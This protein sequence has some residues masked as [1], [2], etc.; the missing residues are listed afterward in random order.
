M[1]A[2]FMKTAGLRESGHCLAVLVR[3]FRNDPVVRWMYPDP[4]QYEEYFPGLVKAFGGKAF[5]HDTAHYAR[6][7]VATALWLPPD[8]LPDEEALVAQIEASIPA[9]NR[10]AVFA[11]FEQMDAW[12]PREPNWHLPLI[13]TDPRHQGKGH[14]TRLLHHALAI[15]DQQQLPA[16][17]E[18]T[19]P[20]NIS[21]YERHGFEALGV[22]Q[23][24][25]SPP[26]IPMLRRP[27]RSLRSGPGEVFVRTREYQN[28]TR[29]VEQVYP[30]T[31]EESRHGCS[32]SHQF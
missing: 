19:S 11:V 6:R 16:Y 3:A 26:I 28:E 24:G 12:H 18:A 10:A 4:V 23:A 27:G 17:L 9:R 20:K 5:E 1:T 2:Q 25:S 30:P 15:C 8:I 31:E 13:G 32:M 21:L 29:V 7:F 14:G 22:I